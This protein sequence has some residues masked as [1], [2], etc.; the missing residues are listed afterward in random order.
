[1]GNLARRRP[2]AGRRRRPVVGKPPR[3][4]QAG[5]GGWMRWFGTRCRRMA[6]PLAVVV[7]LFLAF[8]GIS[9]PWLFERLAVASINADGLRRA[10]SL[11]DAA[12]REGVP[13]AIIDIDERTWK[14]WGEFP[15]TPRDRLA[16]ILAAIDHLPDGD[17]PRA[18]VLDIDLG[19]PV[20][21]DMAIDPL[22]AWMAGRTG[23]VPPLLLPKRLEVDGDGRLLAVASPYDALMRG[24][25][26]LAWVDAS[27]DTDDDGIVRVFPL[28]REVCTVDGDMVLPSVAA[29]LS[30]LLAGDAGTALPRVGLPAAA[31]GCAQT[32]V[33]ESPRIMLRGAGGRIGIA[34]HGVVMT[35][36]RLLSVP[37]RLV[38]D[39]QAA[40]DDAALF[41]GKVV[42]IGASHDAARD[43]HPTL[44][45]YLPGVEI[46]AQQVHLAPLTQ[47]A[48]VHYGL[49]F[50]LVVLALLGLLVVAEL[51][52]RRFRLLV[53]LLVL[54]A[55]AW[56]CV[57]WLGYYAIFDASVAAAALLVS[58]LALR[59]LLQLAWDLANARGGRWKVIVDWPPCGK[60]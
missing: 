38:A 36:P 39:P 31:S 33:A 15:E 11:D 4:S 19:G 20:D 48:G 50:R 60:G 9:T 26:D 37:A 53:L 30:Q 57:H 58:V 8:G 47:L 41:A 28:W 10:I 51:L 45:G 54:L 43:A 42:F 18:I 16:A 59:G 1:M 49:G 3:G 22:H 25:R 32:A 34:G 35:T 17:R 56:A 5:S 23:D 14:E 29:R 55:A 52:L 2:L 6:W 40:R 46:L 27:L 24:R 7:S 21:R 13:V 12:D 44:H